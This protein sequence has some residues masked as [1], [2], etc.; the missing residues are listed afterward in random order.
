M[1][2]IYLIFGHN[3]IYNVKV[4]FMSVLVNTIIEEYDQ[5]DKLWLMIHF[6]HLRS[7]LSLRYKKVLIFL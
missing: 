6:V 1:S 4:I 2:N 3:I 5:W 7:L